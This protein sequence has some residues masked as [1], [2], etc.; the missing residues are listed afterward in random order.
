MD[1][2]AKHLVHPERSNVRVDADARHIGG[3][4]A[5]HEANGV[6]TQ[7]VEL[8]RKLRSRAEVIPPRLRDRRGIPALEV[9]RD[10]RAIGREDATDAPGEPAPLRFDE[11]A[12]AFV[13]A[14]LPGLRPPA[15]VVT[16]R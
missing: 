15:T 6:G 9:G 8:R 2:F 1:P 10:V 3:L 7:G 11:V 12:D 13:R 16:E 4:E 14:P 5:P